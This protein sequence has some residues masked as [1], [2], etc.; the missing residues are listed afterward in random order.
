MINRFNSLQIWQLLLFRHYM[1][2]KEFS[3]S[4]CYIDWNKLGQ[5][6]ARKKAALEHQGKWLLKLP[7]VL[8]AHLLNQSRKKKLSFAKADSQARI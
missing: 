3:L 4:L 5:M 2:H 7:L 6:L 1:G 8:P